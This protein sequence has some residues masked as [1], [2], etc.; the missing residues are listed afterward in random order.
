MV[1][2][3]EATIPTVTNTFVVQAPREHVWARLMEV[4]AYSAW[5]PSLLEVS[6]PFVQDEWLTLTY[7]KTRALVPHVFHVRIHRLEEGRAVRWSAPE[8]LAAHLFAAD[9]GLELEDDGELT[10]VTHSEHFSGLFAPLL[11]WLLRASVDA[12]HAGFNEALQDSFGS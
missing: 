4:E 1:R 9:H 5:N 8:G 6:A 11:V 7:A 10:R 2:P 3:L 12:G